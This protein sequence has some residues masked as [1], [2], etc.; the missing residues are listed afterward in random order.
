MRKI[1]SLAETR[2]DCADCAGAKG[3]RLK[4]ERVMT[5]RVHR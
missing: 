1:V 2:S 4:I 5:F 3:T